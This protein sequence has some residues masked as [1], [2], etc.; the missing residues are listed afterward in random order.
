MGLL[1]TSHIELLR[2]QSRFL[3]I[4]KT[5]IPAQSDPGG[6]NARRL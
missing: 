3:Q 2:A 5:L 4:M 1:S 6:R